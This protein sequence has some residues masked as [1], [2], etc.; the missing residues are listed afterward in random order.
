MI[1][2]F[3]F[4]ERRTGIL[5]IPEILFYVSNEQS[6]WII[7]IIMAVQIHRPLAYKHSITTYKTFSIQK[8]SN[9][10]ID[11]GSYR[12]MLIQHFAED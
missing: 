12:K 11:N 2:N 7:V 8:D 9:T 5:R 4:N 10:N 3:F 6:A 1:R